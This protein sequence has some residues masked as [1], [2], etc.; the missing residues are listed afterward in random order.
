MPSETHHRN[1]LGHGNTRLVQGLNGTDGHEI[2]TG[3]DGRYVPGLDLIQVAHHR[4]IAALAGKKSQGQTSSQSSS[5]PKE[6]K[7][8]W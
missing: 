8:S 6:A 2:V 5:R 7:P 1:L 3:H 4:F